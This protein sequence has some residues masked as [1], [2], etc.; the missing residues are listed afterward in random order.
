MRILVLLC[1]R[2]LWYFRNE[3]ASLALYSRRRGHRGPLQATKEGTSFE[4]LWGR[5]LGPALVTWPCSRPSLWAKKAI[6]D[7]GS[8][9]NAWSAPPGCWLLLVRL[10]ARG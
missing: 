6:E 8:S 5:V 3:K 10:A 9:T 7:G 1:C 2:L 4:L